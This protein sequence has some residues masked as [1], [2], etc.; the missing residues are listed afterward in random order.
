MGK[1]YRNHGCRIHDAVSIMGIPALI[2]ENEILQVVVLTGK[3]AD[4][5]ELL[6]KPFDID[7]LW[8]SPTG[9]INPH[10]Y[11]PSLFSQSGS[12]IDLYEGG[13]Q[14]I[15]PNG[16]TSCLIDGIAVGQHGTVC[17]Q[18][19]SYDIVHDDAEEISVQFSIETPRF[20]F[21][22]C[23]T[24]TLK[25]HS[26]RIWF[27]EVIENLGNTDHIFMI[28][29]HPALGKP[30][31]NNNCILRTNAES[32][33]MADGDTV[34]RKSSWPIAPDGLNLTFV[35]QSPYS[36]IYYLTDF[37]A[38]AM[39]S[40]ENPDLKLR[41][42]LEWGKNDYSCAWIWYEL[43]STNKAPWFGRAHCMAAEPWIGY[44]CRGLEAA[45][46]QN[47]AGLLKARE[48]RSISM[49][50]SIISTVKSYGLCPDD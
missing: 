27:N 32:I 19:W 23:R 15:F 18:A 47:T 34:A 42:Q 43:T 2:M 31:L 13:W 12:F 45:R 50:C 5:F 8:H 1:Y 33:L 26:S 6:Y 17:N 36:G 37:P 24:M 29:H 20:P 49:R 4:I 9:L 16:G 10:E 40:V 7:L 41:F 21:R 44:P 46:R 11:C 25:A 14:E 28:G 30:F 39:L 38:E 22:L 35:P 3:G 48:K